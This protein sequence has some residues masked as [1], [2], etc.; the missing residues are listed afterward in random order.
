MNKHANENK[1]KVQVAITQGNK[2]WFGP[3]SVFLCSEAWCQDCARLM[4]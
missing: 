2:V 4:K 1:E 3:V